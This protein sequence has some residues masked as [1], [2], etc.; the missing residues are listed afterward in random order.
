MSLNS[1]SQIF[2][3]AWQSFRRNIWLSIATIIMIV[4]AFVSVNILI[5][6]NVVTDT[7]IEMVKDKIDISVY[8]N[9]TVTEP[10]VLEVKTY[11]SSLTQVQDI[12]YISQQQALQK[13]RQRHQS[14]TLIIQSLEELD[15]N[16]LGATLI[17]KAK[18]IKDYPEIINVLDNS[19]YNKLI[20]DKSFDDHEAYIGKIKQISDNINLVGF[21]ASAIFVLIALMIIFNTIRV[22]IYTHREEI[23]IMKL[24]GATNWFIRSPFLLEGIFYGVIA[25]TLSLLIIYPLLNFIQP[26][27]NSFFLTD[28]FN[29]LQKL[30]QSFWPLFLIE[31]LTI[32]VL[33]IIGSYIAIRRY[34]KV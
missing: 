31:L 9:D 11:L 13:F 30:Q 16:P 22:A 12:T 25:C 7:A 34:L 19:K 18:D 21:G 14:D 24:V 33:N 10:Q 15:Q 20:S 17:V 29:L 26:Y 23:N 6:L 32:A 2:I 1:I 8:F 4:L 3:F 5:A 28:G 27:L